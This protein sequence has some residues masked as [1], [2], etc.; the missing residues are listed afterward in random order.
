MFSPPD[1]MLANAVDKRYVCPEDITSKI[2]EEN[3]PNSQQ[4]AQ[5]LRAQGHLN[6]QQKNYKSAQLLKTEI[7]QPII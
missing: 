1:Q 4:I 6:R 2:I 3:L 7:S 5:G